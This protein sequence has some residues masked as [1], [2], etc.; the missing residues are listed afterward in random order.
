M[1]PQ[2]KRDSALESAISTAIGFFIAWI[3]NVLVVP[4][5]FGVQMSIGQGFFHV[6]LFTVL[7]FVR[8]YA[9]RRAFARK[10]EK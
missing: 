7:S 2:S 3:A 9:V 6:L 8:Q 4:F 1:R 10:E 5:L